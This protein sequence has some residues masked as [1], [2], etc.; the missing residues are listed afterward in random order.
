M[1]PDQTDVTVKKSFGVENQ[2]DVR[3]LTLFDELVLNKNEHFDTKQG[4]QFPKNT[5]D[6]HVFL[7]KH[8]TTIGKFGSVK[9][10][11]IWSK[12]ITS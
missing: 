6:S 12:D 3:N 4:K 1:T 2:D 9:F 5:E 7:E 10:Y 11:T 8:K